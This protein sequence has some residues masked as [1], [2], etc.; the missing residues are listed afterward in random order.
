MAASDEFYL[1]LIQEIIPVIE[2]FGTA[3]QVRSVSSGVLNP[4]TLTAGPAGAPREVLG[5]VDTAQSQ[6]NLASQIYAVGESSAI[7]IGRKSLILLPDANPTTSEEIL[8][9]GKWFSLGKVEPIKP[10]DVV[11]LYML[12]VT[13]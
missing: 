10:A 3:Y 12:D 1:E 5:L 6:F 11:V 2:E 4:D 9:D 7:K 13:T 8:V